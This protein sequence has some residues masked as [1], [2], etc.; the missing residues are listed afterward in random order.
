MSFANS[1]MAHG[2]D[3]HYATLGLLPSAHPAVVKATIRALQNLHHPDKGGD[4][5]EFAKIQE[6]AEA[7]QGD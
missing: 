1:D 3:K 5:V 4:P 6:A 2:L 7:I